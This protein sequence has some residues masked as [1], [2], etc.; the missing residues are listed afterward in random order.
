MDTSHEIT[1]DLEI[2]DT[3]PLVATLKV[4]GELDVYTA[5]RLR[6]ALAELIHKGSPH[7]AVDMTEISFVESVGVAVLVRAL[8][9]QR[10]QSHDFSLVGLQPVPLSVFRVMG[11]T[12][13]FAIHATTKE[14]LASPRPGEHIKP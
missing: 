13:L 2:D 8:K 11:L 6:D 7:I 5:P 3:H 12:T 4:R 10:N 9:L 1:F 14:A